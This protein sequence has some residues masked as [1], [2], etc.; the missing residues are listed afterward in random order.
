M[1]VCLYHNTQSAN[2]SPLFLISEINLAELCDKTA[3]QKK[4]TDGFYPSEPICRLLISRPMSPPAVRHTLSL[5]CI[6]ISLRFILMSRCRAMRLSLYMCICEQALMHMYKPS[7]HRLQKRANSSL[8]FI[9]P[10]FM[11]LGAQK[12]IQVR[13]L[14]I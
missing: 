1:N 6:R 9:I 3:P 4:S 13:S 2:M 7:A 8:S 5:R 10:W 14:S 12:L 11:G